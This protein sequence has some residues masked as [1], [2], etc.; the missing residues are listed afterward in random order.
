M[1]ARQARQA[2]GEV[3]IRYLLAFAFLAAA[4]A[5]A[6][7]APRFV[8]QRV[9]TGE[10]SGGA[11]AEVAAGRVQVQFEQVDKRGGT[12]RLSKSCYDREPAHK[13][14]HMIPYRV[15]WTLSAGPGRATDLLGPTAR[16]T[17]D[18]RIEVEAGAAACSHARSDGPHVWIVASGSQVSQLVAGV[19]DAPPIGVPFVVK[20]GERLSLAEKSERTTA[21]I[22]LQSGVAQAGYFGLSAHLGFPGVTAEAMYLYRPIVMKPA[23]PAPTLNH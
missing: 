8:L 23:S 4:V 6:D 5:R 3:A 12:I 10:L 18:A 15:S 7:D 14:P 17:L 13:G 21:V 20:A 19:K 16:I 11:H 9:L 1:P 2:R 22:T